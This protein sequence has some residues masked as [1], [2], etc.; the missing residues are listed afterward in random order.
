MWK[1]L[2][3]RRHTQK[4]G[5]KGPGAA[6]Q[7]GTGFVEERPWQEYPS[8]VH[9][10]VP[11]EYSASPPSPFSSGVTSLGPTPI[12]YQ[13]SPPNPD[14]LATEGQSLRHEMGDRTP[15]YELPVAASPQGTQIPK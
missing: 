14:P 4:A 2:L 12:Q 5:E 10:V 13:R 11:V 1:N 6:E 3:L 15:A 7:Q 8:P 9:S